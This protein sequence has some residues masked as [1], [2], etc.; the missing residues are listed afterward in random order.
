MIRRPPRSPLFPYTTLFRSAPPDAVVVA[1]HELAVQREA[2]VAE[3]RAGLL[4][5]RAVGVDLDEDP[6]RPPGDVDVLRHPG[7]DAVGRRRIGGGDAG[8]LDAHPEPPGPPPPGGRA[9][10]ARGGGR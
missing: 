10:G 6:L 8:A 9:P 2:A 3:E 5:G 1:L 4:L 7:T